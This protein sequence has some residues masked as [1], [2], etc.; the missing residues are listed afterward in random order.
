MKRALITLVLLNLVCLGLIVWHRSG[1]VTSA[2]AVGAA[3]MAAT[4]DGAVRNVAHEVVMYGTAW[5]GYCA[6]TRRYFADHGIRYTEHDIE[7]SDDGRR[8]FEALGGGG[9]PV[10]VIDGTV[11]RGFNA[12]AMDALL[13]R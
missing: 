8:G 9:I 12:D 5:C 4:D 6:K 10:V 1:Q 13:A 11:V 2:E 3:P 7:A